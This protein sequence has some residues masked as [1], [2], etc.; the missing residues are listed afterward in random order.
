MYCIARLLLV[1]LEMLACVMKLFQRV[2]LVAGHDNPFWERYKQLHAKL[3][4]GGTF[5][6]ADRGEISRAYIH[7]VLGRRVLMPDKS[8]KHVTGSYTNGD[9]VLFHVTP[10]AGV[11][12]QGDQVITVDGATVIVL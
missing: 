2:R 8:T 3:I 1:L 9:R 11:P 6:E 7:G 12:Q 5:S 10:L 4:A